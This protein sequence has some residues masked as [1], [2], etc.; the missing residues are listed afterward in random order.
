[1][2]DIMAESIK[3]YEFWQTIPERHSLWMAYNSSYNRDD[4]VFWQYVERHYSDV[5][6]RFQAWKATRR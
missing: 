4:C 6:F 5:W 2:D 3:F 1:M